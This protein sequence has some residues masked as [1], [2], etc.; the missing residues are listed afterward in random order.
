LLEVDGAGGAELLAGPAFLTLEKDA[1]IDVD[2]G[3]TRH[4]LREGGIDGLAVAEARLEIL[5]HHLARA[6]F[7]ADAANP[8]TCPPRHAGLAANLDVEMTDRAADFLDFGVGV[9]RD[10]RVLARLGHLGREDAGRAVNGWGRSC[11][12][13]PCAADR[14]GNTQ[15]AIVGVQRK[16]V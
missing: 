9:E 5:V 12:D 3:D 2:H 8:C 11:Q 4:G 15:I 10:V 6:L 16:L 1:G 13:A 7:H 14:G